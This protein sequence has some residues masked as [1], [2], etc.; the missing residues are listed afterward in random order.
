MDIETM[1]EYCLAKR[2][3]TE[4]FPFDD[5]TLVIKVAGKM[6]AVLPLEKPDIVILKC[7]PE[8]AEELRGYYHDVEPAWHFNKKYWN[9]VRF[10]GDVPDCKICEL[11]DHSYEEVLK[12]LPK[13]QKQEL[14]II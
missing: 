8:R 3:A 7:N 5:T 2:H 9:M 6:F 10:N 1:R 13:K 11:V 4:C 12:K 14:G